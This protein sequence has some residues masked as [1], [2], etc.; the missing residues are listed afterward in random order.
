[1][2]LVAGSYEKFIWGFSL[3]TLDSSPSGETLILKPLFSY[4]SHT[5]PIKSVAAAG[6]IAASGGSDD[7]I[8]IYDLT[9]S[10][11]IGS[12]ID[13]SGAVTALAFYTSPIAHSLP[14]NLISA[15]DDGNL[16]IFD[17]DPFVHLKTIPVHRRGVT[18][19]AVHPSGR[20][21]LTVGRD[22]CLAMV[23]LMRG[24]RSFACRLDR[25]A[26]IVK[27]GSEERFFMAAEER[28]T[29]HN[30]EDAKIVQEMVGQKRVLCIATGESGLLFTGGEDKNVIVWDTTSGKVA[31][32]IDGA[33]STRVKGLVI[34][35]RSDDKTHEA[36]NCLASASSD[37]V[38]RIWDLRMVAKEKTTPLAESNTKSRL[39]CLAGSS[40]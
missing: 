18:D 37:G 12:L 1:M 40:I 31:Y 34:F 30:A 14:R 2:S 13:H 15:A 23:N 19:L 32:S 7:T 3:K 22:S 29:V 39:T 27:Y 33:H 20:L 5:A 38:I 11:E 36:L 8:K 10:S 6:P 16:C 17:A 4:P 26:S 9:T 24:R 25:E 28:I 35:K 21:A